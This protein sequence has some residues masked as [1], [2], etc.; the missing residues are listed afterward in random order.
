MKIN[1]IIFIF[2]FLTVSNIIFAVPAIAVIDFDSGNYCT[3]QKAA[4]MTDL[5][6]NELIR[7]GR[8]DVVDRKNMDKIIAEMRFQM[9]DWVNSIKVKQIGQMIGADYIMSGNFDMLGSNLYLVVQMLDIE[10]ARA[11]YS[12]RLILAT[13]EEYD[14]KVQGFA[15]EFIK[16]LPM[17]NIF[18]GT[19][20]SDILH[21]GIIDSYIITFSGSSRCTVK[22]ISLLNGREIIEEGQG[23]YSFDGNIFKIIAVLR[24][25]KIPH[26]NSI[27]WSS[28]ISIGDG[29]R[30]FYMLVKPTSIE[31]N[32]VRVTFS[33]E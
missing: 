2:L 3:I 11:V 30:S 20:S 19:W 4:I 10:T 27:Q 1:F 17:E 24:N 16:K 14:W 23:T 25:S 15:D 26:I 22:V 31:N 7:S 21:D 8:A 13:W 33:K 28:V 29:N 32:L 5:F 18:I 12:S 9:S 6:R